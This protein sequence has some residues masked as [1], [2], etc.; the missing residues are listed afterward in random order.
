VA[1]RTYF[2]RSQRNDLFCPAIG[3][4]DGQFYFGFDILAAHSG[5]GCR[6]PISFEL[7]RFG[8]ED[9]VFRMYVLVQILLKLPAALA[10]RSIAGAGVC[11]KREAAGRSTHFP[12]LIAGLVVLEELRSLSQ[13]SC[14]DEAFR[15]EAQ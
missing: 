8:K 11:G 7:D 9:I 15:R 3:F 14:S 4:F 2:R 13:G 10:E 5:A 1:F 6:S 12:E